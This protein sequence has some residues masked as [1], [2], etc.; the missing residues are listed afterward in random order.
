MDFDVRVP[1]HHSTPA[2]KADVE[3]AKS[4]LTDVYNTV[5]RILGGDHQ[6]TAARHRFTPSG[7]WGSVNREFC[8]L[9]APNS[10]PWDSDLVLRRFP[11]GVR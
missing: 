3:I 8:K 10:V 11:L 6:A 5:T 1:R 4:Y 7:M 9:N 2:T